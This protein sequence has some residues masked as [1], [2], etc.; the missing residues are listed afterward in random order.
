MK[1]KE[2]LAELLGLNGPGEAGVENEKDEGGILDI[3]AELGEEKVEEKKERVI[4]PPKREI[5]MD[6]NAYN[7]IDAKSF[8]DATRIAEFIRNEKM[9]TLNIEYLDEGTA[10]RLMNFL[11]GAMT[12]MEANY[13]AITKKVY[14]II[15]K[16]MTVSYEGNKGKKC[17]SPKIF[18]GFE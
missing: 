11:S 6:N 4:V 14:T 9:F 15:P 17:I 13:V 7:V 18:K 10:L 8:D 2:T 12:V 3:D 1:V 16:S 5:Q